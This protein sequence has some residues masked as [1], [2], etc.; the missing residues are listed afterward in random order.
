MT[1][2]PASMSPSTT[3]D[4]TLL[5]VQAVAKSF[6][7]ATVLKSVSL[8]VMPSEFLT[9]LG[10]SGSGKTTLLRLIAGFERPDSGEIWMDGER[11]DQLP[12]FQRRVHTVFQN[13][14][15]FPHL[16]V[17]DNVAYGLRIHKA[18]G[19][20]IEVR[21]KEALDMV[22]MASF[23][24][25]SSTKLSGGQQ[26]RVALARALV[27]RPRLLLLDEP[28]SALDA[29]LRRQMQSE[30]QSLQRDVGITFVFVTHDQ[31][32]AMALSDRIALLRHG[33]LEQVA[34]PHELYAHPA[35]TYTA[36]FIGQTNLLKS[37][38]QDGIARCGSLKWKCSQPNGPASFSLRPER[39]TPASLSLDTTVSFRATVSS[40]V[41]QGA[42][43]LLQVA[44][45]DGQ[46][47][48]ASLPAGNGISGECE[49]QFEAADAIFVRE[50]SDG[51][52]A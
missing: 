8:D 1:E 5:R 34:T 45:T 41:F 14:A 6:G 3:A 15:L 37:V 4:N 52:G 20:E 42:T 49:W 39:I 12:P 35:T 51:K 24:Q 9:I 10:E 44:C 27:Q 36:A 43:E 31:H 25:A 23:I 13:Y 19:K 22:R 32:E 11:I 21:V 26:Q 28:L 16:S 33:N 46:Q 7:A 40:R 2:Q 48:M 17:F 47:L 18:G 38:V 50:S 29:S 30:L